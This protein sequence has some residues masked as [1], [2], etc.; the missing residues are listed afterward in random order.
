MTERHPVLTPTQA[1]TLAAV[2]R[3]FKE[4]GQSPVLR[5]IEV[6]CE[7]KRTAVVAALAQLEKKGFIHRTPFVARGITIIKESA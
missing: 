6:E 1:H 3:L 2:V 5:E 7:V 4:T